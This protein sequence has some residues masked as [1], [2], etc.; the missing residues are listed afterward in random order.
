MRGLYLADDVKFL[1]IMNLKPAIWLVRLLCL[2]IKR[3]SGH[4]SAGFIC[5]KM[6][7]PSLVMMA[8][9]M[10]AITQPLP[11]QQVDVDIS[12]KADQDTLT[13]MA[14]GGV[15]GN[16]LALAGAFGFNVMDTDV[17][18]RIVEDALIQASAGSIDVSADS[19]TNI[20]NLTLSMPVQAAVILLAARS[21]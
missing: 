14:A 4:R 11:P 9:Q 1:P 19:F 12:A 2:P 13:F 7:A 16:D 18:A 21:R 15:S 17:E 8:A 3:P 6:C 20:R 10:M 5:V